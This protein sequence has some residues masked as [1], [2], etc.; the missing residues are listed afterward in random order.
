MIN[1]LLWITARLPAR[2]ISDDGRPYLERY[3]V[4]HGLGIRIYLHRFVGSDPE[5]GWHDHPWAWAASLVLAGSYLESRRDGLRHRR[6]GNVL[7]GDTF[8]RVILPT[9]ER[10]CWTLFV[11]S[12]RDVKSWGFLA[13]A[14]DTASM[15]WKPYGYSGKQKDPRWELTAPKGREIRR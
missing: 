3:F 11:H 6:W 14:W 2:I 7:S 15:N 10:E 9:G 12:A 5:R 8:H 4:F 13:P 1:L